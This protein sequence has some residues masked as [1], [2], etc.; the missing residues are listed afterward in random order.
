MVDS[1]HSILPRSRVERKLRYLLGDR[2]QGQ[3]VSVIAKAAIDALFVEVIKAASADAKAEGRKRFSKVNLMRVVRAS[4]ELNKVFGNYLF[5]SKDRV[6]VDPLAL[7]TKKRRD[8]A[9]KERTDKKAPTI[10][11]E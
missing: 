1:R 11:E 5:Y 4:P 3:K 6:K 2:R 9:L 8:Q 7:M 10:A